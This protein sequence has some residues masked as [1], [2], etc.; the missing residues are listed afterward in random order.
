MPQREEM[1][2]TQIKGL[3]QNG[4]KGVIANIPYVTSIPFFNTIPNDALKLDK[5]QAGLL[6]QFF[7]AIQQGFTQQLKAKGL[8]EQQA[9][10]LASQY[11]III[12]F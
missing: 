12:A 9:K 3:T 11:G 2:A 6:T 7:G 5:E 8:P 10:A 1:V 4:A